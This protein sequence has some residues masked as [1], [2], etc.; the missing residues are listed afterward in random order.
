MA[1]LCP[2]YKHELT[3]TEM[4]HMHEEGYTLHLFFWDLASI[5]TLVIHGLTLPIFRKD[6]YEFI[7]LSV[8]GGARS[9]PSPLSDGNLD[10]AASANMRLFFFADAF[11]HVQ[12]ALHFDPRLQCKLSV[13]QKP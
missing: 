2:N 8:R 11:K 13:K 4:C 12:Q 7:I 1:C 5:D 10:D 3:M 9:D 6:F